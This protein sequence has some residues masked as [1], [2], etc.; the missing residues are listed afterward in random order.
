LLL[1]ATTLLVLMEIIA[2]PHAV[3]EDD[4]FNGYFLP[5]GTVIFPNTWY[6][7]IDVYDLDQWTDCIW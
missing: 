6:V 1:L 7:W 3:A 2:V 4:E 5:K